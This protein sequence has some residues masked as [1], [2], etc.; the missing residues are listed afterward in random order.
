MFPAGRYIYTG[1]ALK[2]LEQRLARHRR[3]DNTLYWHID[4][5]LRH[6][7]L[8]GV[9]GLR[10]RK[11]RECELNQKTLKQPGAQVVVPGFGS[12]DCWCPTHLVY[13]GRRSRGGLWNSLKWSGGAIRSGRTSRGGSRR[14][15]SSAS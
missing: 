2:G 1:S 12:S 3:R 6:A 13:L 10:T 11:R 5:L 7:R 15:N 4:Y 9:T 8:E 14:R